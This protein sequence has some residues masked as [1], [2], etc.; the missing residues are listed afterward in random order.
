M[1]LEKCAEN[2]VYPGTGNFDFRPV[3]QCR[4][5]VKNLTKHYR[6]VK[7]NNK[8]TGR[9]RKTCKFFEELDL[10]LGHRPATVPTS[11][12]DTGDSPVSASTSNQEADTNLW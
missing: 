5:K 3:E 11:L 9:G 10:I 6:E 2:V 7:D 1:C 12:L 4:N 8:E